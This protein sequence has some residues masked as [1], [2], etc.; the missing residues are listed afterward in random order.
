MRYVTLILYPD[1]EA[2]HPIEQQL[3]EDPSITRKAIHDVKGLDDGTI[4]LLAEVEGD[5]HRY[6][7]IMSDSPSVRTFAASGNDS[8]YVYSQVEP[9]PLTQQLLA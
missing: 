9:T 8:G 2:F 4:A 1:V 6:H 3:T 5:L 7:Q